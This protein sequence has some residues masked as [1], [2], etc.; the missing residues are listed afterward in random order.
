VGNEVGGA[1]ASGE[2]GKVGM[3]ERGKV[4]TRKSGNEEKWERGKVGN[5]GKWG[6]E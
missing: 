3:R 1:R 5:E 6:K 2:R 4:G